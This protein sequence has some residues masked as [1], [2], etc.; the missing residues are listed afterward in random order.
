MHVARKLTQRHANKSINP[1]SG[2]KGITCKL[3]KQI[4]AKGVKVDFDADI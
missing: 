4:E 1:G 3:K 2:S